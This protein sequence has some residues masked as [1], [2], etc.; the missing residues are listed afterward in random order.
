MLNAMQPVGA[1]AVKRDSR[2]KLSTKLLVAVTGLAVMGLANAAGR[3][4]SDDFEA[5]NTSKWSL[6]GSRTMCSATRSS[7]DGR[8]T[9][10]GSYMLECNWNGLVAWDHADSFS[11]AVLP[12]WD[13]SSE[14]LVRMWV[15]YA[16]DVDRVVGAKLMRLYPGGQ[17]GSMYVGGQ[18]EKSGGPLLCAWEMIA[19]S[20]GPVAWGDG[21]PFADGQWHKLEIYVKHNTAGATDGILRIWQD[22]TLKQ[23]ARNLVTAAAG[24]KWYPLYLMSN[25][26][27][28]PGWEHDAANHVY[29]DDIEV[30]S[31]RGSGGSGLLADA[32]IR[33][34]TGPV[35]SAARVNSVN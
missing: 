5:G 8:A 14:F 10:A 16:S 12:S 1:F 20:S 22:G 33:A 28:N 4:F 24:A 29:W 27:N 19:G 32:T 25:W 21:S 17:T 3:V 15:R 9:H 18:L 31:D 11:V 26:S 6:D 13:Y 30:Y 2:F 35:P 23:D 7:I 34:G